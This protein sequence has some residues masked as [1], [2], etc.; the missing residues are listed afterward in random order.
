MQVTDL[1][2]DL[3]T[4]L[5]LMTAIKAGD[6]KLTSV[7]SSTVMNKRVGVDFTIQVY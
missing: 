4:G 5:G 7:V 1:F 6:T 3:L 2:N